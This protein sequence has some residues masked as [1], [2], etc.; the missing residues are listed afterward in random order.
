MTNSFILLRNTKYLQ[1]GFST[2]LSV[3]ELYHKLTFACSRIQT[4]DIQSYKNL[5]HRSA[6]VQRIYKYT[7]NI[8]GSDPYWFQYI[9]ELTAQANHEGIHYT[10][11]WN[12]L[13]ADN[14][15]RLLTKLLEI[16]LDATIQV[17]CEAISKH[18][19]IVAFY[20]WQM[21]ERA[22]SSLLHKSLVADWIWYIYEFQLRISTHAYGII[23]IHQM[24]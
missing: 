13:A 11:F 8:V 14:H 21:I 22:V 15:W 3:I 20:F 10:L 7:P 23:E 2:W 19:H 9:W 12:F 16:K 17:K 6:Y 1:R 18:P 5:Q 4:S 24:C